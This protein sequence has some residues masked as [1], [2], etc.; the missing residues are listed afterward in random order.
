MEIVAS[1]RW[2]SLSM[3]SERAC[4]EIGVRRALVCPLVCNLEWSAI[5][6]MMNTVL[7]TSDR[8]QGRADDECVFLASQQVKRE[9]K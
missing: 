4:V 9:Q 1:D 6:E 8:I 7:L 2:Q 5:S 3:G